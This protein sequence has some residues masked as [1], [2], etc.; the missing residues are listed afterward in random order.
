MCVTSRIQHIPCEPHIIHPHAHH[1][2]IHS[3]HPC[4]SASAIAPLVEAICAARPGGVTAQLADESFRFEQQATGILGSG[5][6]EAATSVIVSAT[7][8][9]LTK[10][11]TAQGTVSLPPPPT[12]GTASAASLPVHGAMVG[13]ELIPI[14]KV[15]E[16]QA[17]EALI[18]WKPSWDEYLKWLEDQG[19]KTS[20]I[21]PPPSNQAVDQGVEAANVTGATEGPSA[22]T[23][24]TAIWRM[25]EDILASIVMPDPEIEVMREKLQAAAPTLGVQQGTP[26]AS[27]APKEDPSPTGAKSPLATTG[28]RVDKE[29]G[30][31][32]AEMKFG[33]KSRYIC[34]S[35]D[36]S[37]AA[38]YIAVAVSSFDGYLS[39][40]ILAEFGGVNEDVMEQY[41][42]DW[43]VARLIPGGMWTVMWSRG[44]N[45]LRDRI[46]AV[47]R[48]AL[49]LAL[50][51]AVWFGDLSESTK[52]EKAAKNKAA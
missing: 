28:V 29:T 18:V 37:E 1:V 16:A 7:A 13:M 32:V 52:P 15:V 9:A 47:G 26:A 24:E 2:L 31:A 43:N 3:R 30:L 41:K 49:M 11:G 40:V 25:V 45:V 12:T 5:V 39:D 38:Y 27:S 50:R 17:V 36:K 51:P 44:A 8:A 42:L 14:P 20:K 33:K 10:A 34:R 48:A 35:M 23:D 6:V 22:T 21:P 19:K 46:T 4:S